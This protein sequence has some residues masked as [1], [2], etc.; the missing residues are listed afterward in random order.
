MALLND[1][2]KLV[3]KQ[4]VSLRASGSVATGI[5]HDMRAGCISTRIDQLR[6]KS[7]GRIC[8]NANA[9]EIRAE[10]RFHP[11]ADCGI[12][13]LATGAQYS[14]DHR[15]RRFERNF[16]RRESPARWTRNP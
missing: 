8:V 10:I 9:T 12:E 1:V 3:R 6:R 15:R 13:L 4:A 7:C 14:L 2:S 5:K 11:A 16:F